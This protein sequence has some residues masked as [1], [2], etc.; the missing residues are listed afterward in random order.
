MTIR[1]AMNE[2]SE[3]AI[4]AYDGAHEVEQSDE[5]CAARLRSV[6]GFLYRVAHHLAE[7]EMMELAMR[8]GS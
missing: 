6:G 5:A 8:A 1:D 7:V 2:V 4:V 3:M